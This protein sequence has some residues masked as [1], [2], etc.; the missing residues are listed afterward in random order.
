MDSLLRHARMTG[1]STHL[2]GGGS[3]STSSADGEKLLT[4]IV[5]SLPTTVF[6][7]VTNRQ[8]EKSGFYF[9]PSI[10]SPPPG[11]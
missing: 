11:I 10:F 2:D 9:P 8:S 6:S 7:S 3:E 4:V 5:L 1:T